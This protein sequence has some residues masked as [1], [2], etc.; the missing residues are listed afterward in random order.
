[1]TIES[2]FAQI[3]AYRELVLLAIFAAP[4][5]TWLICYLIPGYR[6]EPMVLS[7][8]LWMALFTVMLWTGYLAYATNLG[9][10]SQVVQQADVLLLI[11]PPYYLLT[12]LWLSK[13]RIPLEWIPAFRTLQGLVALTAAFLVL[14]W[15]LSRIRIVFFSYLPFSTFLVVLALIL[16]LGYWSYRRLLT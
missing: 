4:W 9:G 5:I 12:S 1:M 14:S 6:E 11:A 10:W 2:A 7:V 3:L 8:N 16:L 15:I 13:R